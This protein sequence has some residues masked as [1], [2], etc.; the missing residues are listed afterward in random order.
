MH[1]KNTQLIPAKALNA[2][3]CEEN[4]KERVSTSELIPGATLKAYVLGKTTLQLC[5]LPW[6]LYLTWEELEKSGRLLGSGES[7]ED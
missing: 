3:E 5:L 7:L 6:G 1:S 4:I 2:W